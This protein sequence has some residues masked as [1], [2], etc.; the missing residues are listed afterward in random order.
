MKA[1]IFDPLWDDLVTKDLNEQI[2]KSGLETVIVKDVE[3]ISD[4][5]LLFSGD[6]DRIICLNPDYVNWKLTA[7]DYKSIPGLKAILV[8][9]TSYSWIDTTYADEN[10]IPICNIRDFSTEAVAEWAITML[11]NVARQIPC[12]IKNDF[13]LDFD[14]DF[15]KYRGIELKGKKAAIIG[16]GN[17]GHAIAARAQGLGMDIV[18]WSRSTKNNAYKYEELNNIFA[19]ADVIFP[20]M[21][22]NDES[23]NL[24]TPQLLSTMKSSAILISI[25][26]DL[27][28]EQIVLDLVKDGKLFGFGFEAAPKEFNKYEGNIW[29]APAYAW[30]TDGSMNNSMERWVDN[31][32]GAKEGRF[33]NQIN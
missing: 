33:P 27:F 4:N 3:P 5:Q 11:L 30:V 10:S 6:E 2:A 24:I 32:I 20:A 16:L 22:V 1:F 31:M 18:Y 9:S 12:L 19:T 26:H 17:I 13:P 29:A 23:K 8:A 14:K 28:N 15:M 21:A 7:A 25:V